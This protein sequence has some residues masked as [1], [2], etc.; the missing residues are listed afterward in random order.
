MP[1]MDKKLKKIDDLG[2]DMDYRKFPELKPK[3]D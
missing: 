3:N 2:L 1:E